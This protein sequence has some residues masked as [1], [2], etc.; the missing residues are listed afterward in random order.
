VTQER[1]LEKFTLKN[2]KTG[3]HRRRRKSNSGQQNDAWTRAG[4]HAGSGCWT[5][6]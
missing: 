1:I 2:V 6:V 3:G 5:G 4:R